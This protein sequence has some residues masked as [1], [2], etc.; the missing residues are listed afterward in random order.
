MITLKIAQSIDGRITA[1]NGN[2]KWIS[3]TRSRKYIHKM[4]SQHDAILT[5]IRTVMNDDPLLNVRMVDGVSPKRIVLD[6]HLRIPLNARLLND[7]LVSKTMI[8]TTEAAAGEKTRKVL[9]K[10]AKVWEMPI[11][12]NKKIDLLATCKKLGQEGITSLLVEGGSEIFSSFLRARLVDKVAFFIA[13]KI[14]G[15]GLEAINK[16][17]I[18]SLTNC[19]M[20]EEM[21]NKRIGEDVLITGRVVYREK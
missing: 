3:S 9:K 18:E 13:P 20:I 1:V 8:M 16:V 6:S 10:G 2:S 11:E 5:G 19:L 4:R 21:R 17:G 12:E 15:D 7:S 14:L